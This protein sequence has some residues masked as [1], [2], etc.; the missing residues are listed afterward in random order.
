M[1]VKYLKLSTT[2]FPIQTSTDAGRYVNSESFRGGSPTST[3]STSPSSTSKS[4]VEPRPYL[5]QDD[6][7]TLLG[8]EIDPNY[9]KTLIKFLPDY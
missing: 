8:A 4:R 2:S 9:R 6:R 1:I 3:S 7:E 5:L